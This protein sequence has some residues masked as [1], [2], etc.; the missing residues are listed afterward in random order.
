MKKTFLAAFCFLTV[1]AFAQT[2]IGIEAG[3]NSSKLGMTGNNQQ[4]YSLSGIGTFDIGMIA[5]KNYS[6]NFSLSSGLLFF[7]K[8][9][10]K[11]KTD[12]AVSGS[13]TTTKIN[14]L[15]VPLNLNFKYPVDKKIQVL[16]TTGLYGA[17][18][19]SGSEKGTLETSS[20]TTSINNSIHFTNNSSYYSS[21]KTAVKPFDFGYHFSAGIEWKSYQLRLNYN[22]GFT[23]INPSGSTKF[24]NENLGVSLAYLLS[25]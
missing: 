15:Q 8:G 14:Y 22:H 20:S 16:L 4:Y 7:Q 18:G 24:Y 21:D 19:I 10:I 9:G 17:Y 25:K 11:N 12:F 3:Y 23:T 13:N 5:E 1:S 2:K 6:K